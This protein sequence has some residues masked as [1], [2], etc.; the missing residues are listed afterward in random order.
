MQRAAIDCC[1][2][3][4]GQSAIR[5]AL[6][7]GDPQVRKRRVPDHG[8][9]IIRAMSTQTSDL[10]TPSSEV[11]VQSLHD[12]Q[13]RA[14]RTRDA[15]FDGRLFVGVTSTGIYCR[16]VCR[17]RPPRQ[18]NCRFFANAASAEH[19]GFRPCLRC[20]PELA[21][22]LSMT[23]SSGTLAGQ[24]AV[25][26]HQSVHDGAD[27]SV[28][29]LAGR[30]GV[31]DRHLRRIFAQ[32]HG[33]SPIDYLTTQRL[34]LAK[35]M[36]TDTAMP[37]TQVALAAGFGSLRRFNAVFLA[38]YRMSPG[39]LR[40]A[41][42]AGRATDEVG[43]GDGA[44]L[45]LAWR[46]PYDTS[47]VMRFFA[48]RQIA[49]VERVDNL[50]WQRSLA[51]AHAGRRLSGWFSARLVPERNE[52]ALTVS[53]GLM[54]ALGGVILR[55]RHALDLDADPAQIDP[56]LAGIVGDASTPPPRPGLRLTSGPDGFETAVR[57]ILGQQVTVAAARTLTQRLVA[58]FGASIETPFDAIDR[59][60]PDADSLAVA[61]P[62]DIG[63]LGIVRQRVG[64][65]QALARAVASGD[66]QLHRAAP[67]PATLDAL[68]ALPGIGEWTVQLIAMRALGWP[69]AWPASDIAILNA[70]GTRDIKAATAQAEAWRPWRAYAVM[71]L[72]Q[73]LE[74]TP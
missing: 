50:T 23:D 15:R 57:V 10:Q 61:D 47:G 72:W 19:Q 28:A 13:Y 37:V 22:G 41:H 1:V 9:P 46:S 49:G 32:A 42:P 55:L 31:T 6:R 16:P 8:L 67:L 58:R 20:R 2:G 14:L 40:R 25:M 34:L 38:R 48:Q 54:P 39:A 63:T 5:R 21:P 11:G 29:A 26:L 24:A 17:V 64:A 27:A 66:I 30:L 45:R 35:H 12:A 4:A 62:A 36:L 53:P 7:A 69:D 33:I 44:T 18:A 59:L 43:G 52:V 71:R 68:R 3:T 73:L 51:L 74:K 60:F 65:I 70:L 56:L